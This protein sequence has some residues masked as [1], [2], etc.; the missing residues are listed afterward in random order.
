MLTPERD[1][2]GNFTKARR[3]AL[4]PPAGASLAFRLQRERCGDSDNL[5]GPRWEGGTVRISHTALWLAA[6]TVFVS[7]AA[8][9]AGR[10]EV[11]ITQRVLSDGQ[12]RYS[13]PVFV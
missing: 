10:V 8:G 7:S 6:A 11:P 1:A 5:G 9:A 3:C 13:I 12:I 2:V 4:A